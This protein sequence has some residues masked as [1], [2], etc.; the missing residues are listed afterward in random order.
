MSSKKW[1]KGKVRWFDDA[2]GWGIVVDENQKTYEVHYSA[3]QSK[4]NWKSLKE[5]SR[6]QFQPLNDPDFQ[7]VER[8]KEA[9]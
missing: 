4:D 1:L 2:S 9:N 7:I 3:I 5:E 8:I 6:V